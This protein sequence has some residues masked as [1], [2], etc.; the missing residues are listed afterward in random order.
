MNSSTPTL[1]KTLPTFFWHFIKK[2]WKAILIF[3]FFS[4][5]WSFDHTLFPY[6]L[7][8]IIDVITSFQGERSAIWPVLTPAL[9]MGAALWVGGEIFYRC[10]GMLSAKITPQM[11]ANVRMEMFDY[12]QY[13]SYSYF[14]KSF[15]GTL[16]NKISDMPSSMTHIMQLCCSLFAPVLLAILISSIF[17]AKLSP[18][19]A[20]ILLGW[21]C[22][23][24]FICVTFSWRCGHYSD[25]HAESRSQLSGKIV[26]SFTN[27]LNVRLFSQ[28]RFERSFL[29]RY[30]KDEKEKREQSLRYIEKM[31]LVMGIASFLGVGLL[32]NG[33]MLYSWQQGTIST[34]DVVFIFNTS[35]NITI[36]CWLAALE[37]PNLFR[38]IGIC[39][40]ALTIIQDAHDIVDT[41]QAKPLKVAKGEITFDNVSFNYNS[42]RALFKNKNITLNAGH[43]VGLVGFSG[44]G[45]TT[46]VHLILRY[47]NTEK[48][49]ILID[50]Q[51][52][53]HVSAQT[54]R[55]QIAMIPQDASLFH[56]T[57]MENIRYG[58]LDATD[59]EVIEAAKKAHCHAFI[60]QLPEK[61]HTLAGERGIK[62]SGGQRQRIIIARAILKNAPILILD[63]ATSALDSMT[64]KQIQEGLEHLMQE[65]TCIVIAHRL[66]TLSGMD[67][68]LVFK[69]GQ[70]VED[71]S[72][73]EL[74]NAQSHYAEMWEMQ[75]G[76][77]L[78]E[79][80]DW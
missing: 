11:E 77:F 43:K 27:H 73:D 67:R 16:A 24:T 14:N 62:L 64:E 34:G 22:I 20:L 53:A 58:R 2:Q 30:Q 76:G 41:S 54:L 49:R 45:K 13:H 78:P 57:L 63:E 29:E 39:K 52:I 61:Y 51:D 35:W 28:H 17:F 74:L 65:R 48:G 32:L 46:F 40:Q 47:F 6:V 60:E 15:A 33:Y 12:V 55:S 5:G 59:E 36:M 79:G 44:S 9:L 66:S 21:V 80:D 50:G 18:L 75:A 25:L 68:I 31:K 4:F 8:W 72:H 37:L 19:F 26:D 23:H 71:G 69:E 10:A 38:E 56:R 70:I 3:Q 42:H 7:S 1:P